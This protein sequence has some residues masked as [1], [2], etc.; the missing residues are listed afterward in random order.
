[1]ERPHEQC[2]WVVEARLLAGEYPGQPESPEGRR[3][4]AFLL[5]CGFDY[6]LDLTEPGEL[7]TYGPLVASRGARH[8]RISLVDM[9]VPSDAGQMAAIL[10]ALDLALDAGRRIYL[11][12]RGGVGRTGTVVGCYLVRHGMSGT[13]AL[14]QIAAWWRT[15]AKRNFYPQSPQT[16]AQI[17][18]V[19]NWERVDPARRPVR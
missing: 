17:A 10:D 6:F 2:Y 8:H 11:H 12:C 9:T 18:F 19:R 5:D 1:M 7:A 13:Q 15:T 4:I 14:D 3:R 16:E